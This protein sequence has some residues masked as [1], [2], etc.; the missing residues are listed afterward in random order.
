[1]PIAFQQKLVYNTPAGPLHMWSH[2]DRTFRRELPQAPAQGIVDITAHQMAHRQGSMQGLQVILI[3]CVVIPTHPALKGL[4]DSVL[5][6]QKLIHHIATRSWQPECRLHRH[7]WSSKAM[8]MLSGLNPYTCSS[9]LQLRR[10]RF[11]LPLDLII[12]LRLLL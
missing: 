7:R 10:C 5:K 8:H 2:Q 12:E 1:M 6:M 11:G 9:R 4:Q 3:R